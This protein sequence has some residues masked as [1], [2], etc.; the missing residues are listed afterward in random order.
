M[1]RITLISNTFSDYHRQM[2]AV[3]SWRHLKNLFPDV[4]D[5]Y[6][7]QFEDEFDTFTDHYAGIQTSF[8]LQQSSKTWEPN[9]IKKLPV[10]FEMIEEGF[11]LT[12]NEYLVYTNSDV[13]LL[14]RLIEY[15]IKEEPDCLASPRLDIQDIISFQ[16]V[17]DEKVVPVRL[18]IAGYDIFSFKRSWW[19]E[20]KGYF[21]H[22]FVIGKPVFD[23]DYAGLMVMFGKKY[24]IANNFPIMGLHIHHGLAA[25]T[26]DCPEKT[27]NESVHASNPLLKIANNIMFHNLQ[28]NLCKR[29]PWGAFLQPQKDEQLIQKTFFDSMNIH[30]DNQIK[31]IE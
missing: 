26:T 30:H 8:V 6:N 15:I 11:K 17:L 2:V 27:W 14:P 22:P 31:Y 4:L 7:L 10:L 25:V 28:N 24:H 29:K 20:F 18:E 3:E 1:A 16:D 13:I 21:D 19:N 23:V 12:D 5:I 9:S